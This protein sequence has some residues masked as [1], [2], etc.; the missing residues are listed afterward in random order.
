MKLWPDI[1]EL[2]LKFKYPFTF[3][4]AL[5]IFV[6]LTIYLGQEIN[7]CK[8]ATHSQTYKKRETNKMDFII[9]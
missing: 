4:T 9:K 5:L 3:N 2:N 8:S 1:I 6:H 7:T